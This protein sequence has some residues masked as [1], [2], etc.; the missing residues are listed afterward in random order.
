MLAWLADVISYIDAIYPETVMTELGFSILGEEE[1]VG[2]GSK[3]DDT[4][5]YLSLEFF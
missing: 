2:N 5:I 4:D 1:R 3:T